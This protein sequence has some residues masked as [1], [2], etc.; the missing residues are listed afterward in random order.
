MPKIASAKS[1]AC[2]VPWLFGGL[3]GL[4]FC[5]NRRS[6]ITLTGV[7]WLQ[8]DSHHLVLAEHSSEKSSF[9]PECITLKMALRVE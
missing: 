8:F 4:Q 2:P 6:R 9:V 3:V 1:I 7:F 5:F